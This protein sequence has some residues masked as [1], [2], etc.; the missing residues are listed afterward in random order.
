M[1]GRSRVTVR[2]RDFDAA[3]FDLDGVLTE[4]ARLHAAAW[5][6]VFDGFLRS[7]ADR[8]GEPFRAF[9][10]V[11]DYLA[12]VDGR[13]RD[14]GIR[15]FLRSRGIS[16]PEGRDEGSSA[17]DS[18]RALGERKA[19]FFRESLQAGIEP[20]PGA[21]E[22]LQNLRRASIKTAVASSSKHSALILQSE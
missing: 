5:K 3:L 10:D 14:D 11:A 4:T 18:V 17:P 12:Y 20:S 7:W 8:H 19:R 2:R 15:C 9:D 16:L 13:P 1:Q 22:L 6:A 21:E